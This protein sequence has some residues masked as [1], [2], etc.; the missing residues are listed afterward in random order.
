M[1]GYIFTLIGVAAVILAVTVFRDDTV[2]K[3]VLGCS[4][5]PLF[6]IGAF[7]KFKTLIEMRRE[8][9]AKVAEAAKKKEEEAKSK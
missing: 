2:I 6:V 5:F 3:W 1:I 7:I 8:M 4:S 9:D